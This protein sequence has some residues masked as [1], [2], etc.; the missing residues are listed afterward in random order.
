MRLPRLVIFSS[1]VSPG[2]W[3]LSSPVHAYLGPRIYRDLRKLD[4]TC[5]HR[6]MALRTSGD[7]DGLLTPEW[8]FGSAVDLVDRLTC[9]MV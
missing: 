3:S 7:E 6:P 1:E 8:S 4:R 2:N 9:P 5:K